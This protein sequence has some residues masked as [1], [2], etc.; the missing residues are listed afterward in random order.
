MTIHVPILEEWSS[1]VANDVAL[2]KTLAADEAKTEAEIRQD[3]A[4]QSTDSNRN[5]RAAML[6]AGKTPSPAN[7]PDISAKLSHL[8]DIRV[9]RTLQ[10]E[11]EAKTR[12]RE[13]TRL[14][15]SLKP[16]FDASAKRFADAL[17]VAHS[18]ALEMNS[19]ESKLKAQGIGFY[20]VVC[21]IN[22]EKVIGW[23]TDK[24]SDFAI[25]L[26]EC[27]AMKHIKSMPREL[28]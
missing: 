12:Y 4:A 28:A 20:P 5:E 6:L 7:T 15:L 9:A 18:A 17:V 24:T 16:A 19:L 1:E 27:V 23:P 26:R 3:K 11:K 10:F 8:A 22:T 2:H 13:G 14:C 21:N 25:L